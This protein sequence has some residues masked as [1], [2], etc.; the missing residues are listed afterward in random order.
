LKCIRASALSLNKNEE[1]TSQYF[2]KLAFFLAHLRASKFAAK[3]PRFSRLA[4][5]LLRF[6][7]FGERGGNLTAQYFVK[8]AFPCLSLRA[9]L[10]AWQSN[11]NH[12]NTSFWNEAKGE[13]IESK[14]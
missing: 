6:L 1:S 5:I 2:V 7:R 3:K 4:C 11:I 13:V 8:L 9:S 10:R 14:K 12:Y